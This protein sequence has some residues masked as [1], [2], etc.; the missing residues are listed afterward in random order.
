MFELN[1]SVCL[2]N[3][4]C[5]ASYTNPIWGTEYQC[6]GEISDK[7]SMLPEIKWSGGFKCYYNT[8]NLRSLK[9]IIKEDYKIGNEVKIIGRSVPEYREGIEYFS[10][11]KE[12]R[13]FKQFSKIQKICGRGD[14]SNEENCIVV[15]EN[16]FSP[17]DLI[18]QK[19]TNNKDEEWKLLQVVSVKK[20]INKWMSIH[21]GLY[22]QQCNEFVK[23]MDDMLEYKN[24][25]SLEEFTI[26]DLLKFYS[27]KR[28]DWL[29]KHGFIEK[30]K[31]KW[32]NLLLEYKDNKIHLTR[33]DG[34]KILVFI[35][36][37]KSIS[38]NRNFITKTSYPNGDIN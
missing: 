35:P 5:E 11:F 24:F 21:N 27:C 15:D 8:N 37:E 28:F 6:I 20:I 23:L 33:S 1:E 38:V 17:Q 10:K 22:N 31:N 19:T 34:R 4:S 16:F 32:I 36:S 3:S 29:I 14:G 7:H 13:N 25:D 12:R 30:I 9:K 2:I 26:T 18:I